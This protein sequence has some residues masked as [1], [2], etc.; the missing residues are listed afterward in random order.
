MA[1]SQ[2]HGFEFEKQIKSKLLELLYLGDDSGYTDKWDFPPIS[3]KSFGF[4]AGK[5][6]LSSIKNIFAIDQN[7]IFI[8]IGWKQ[9]GD[10]KRV[11]F[12]DCIFVSKDIMK[13]LRGSLTYERVLELETKLKEFKGPGV[14]AQNKA[15]EW[16]E[17]TPEHLDKKDNLHKITQ[18]NV[19]FKVDSKLQRRI[20]CSIY[21]ENLY[22]HIKKEI[23]PM[24]K[25]NI[26]DIYSPPRARHP[27]E[28]I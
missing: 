25:L 21:L 12:S 4:S 15:I 10:M 17:K 24:N 23:I 16:Y 26:D 1:E 11:V 20:Q 6:D 18:F 5:I 27:K 14:A 19:H 9:D 2:S 28:K 8:L 7:F 3:I 22:A 13:I